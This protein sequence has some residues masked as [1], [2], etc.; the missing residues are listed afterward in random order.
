MKDFMDEVTSDFR[1]NIAPNTD[2]VGS[3]FI[4]EE[5]KK[6]LETHFFL[7]NFKFSL[8]FILE[9]GFLL[10]SLIILF[11][12]MYYVSYYTGYLSGFSKNFQIS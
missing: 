11:G 3:V 10:A 4:L 9:I 6:R 7:R 1:V 8:L 2:L 12:G 5:T